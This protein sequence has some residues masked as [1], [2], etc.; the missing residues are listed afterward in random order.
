MKK[1]TIF[2]II[3]TLF[4]LTSGYRFI[5]LN[6]SISDQVEYTSVKENQYFNI[7]GIDFKVS[8][9]EFIND[10]DDLG[11]QQLKVYIDL[12]K[13]GEI[14]QDGFDKEFP[15]Y[16]HDEIL[17]NLTDKSGKLVDNHDSTL[18][19]AKDN[20]KFVEIIKGERNI[21][22]EKESLIL[23]F[24]LDKQVMDKVKNNEYNVKVVF[25][26]DDKGLKFNYVNISV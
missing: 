11:K 4:V 16:Y 13:N 12:N 21:G 26:R 9:S 20:P 24:S 25:P 19:F 18:G 2:I 22:E 7:N 6:K 15:K 1:R 5:K 10:L 3:I 8:K 23:R 17:L 14:V